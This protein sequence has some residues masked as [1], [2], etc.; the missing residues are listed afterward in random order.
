M[1]F[2]E[3]IGVPDIVTE[4]RGI[5]TLGRNARIHPSFQI[6]RGPTLDGRGIHVGDDAVFFG[7]TMLVLGDP[8]GCPQAN[9]RIGSGVIMNMSA[10]IS[11]EGGLV[12]EDYALIGSNS[13]ILTGGHAIHDGDPIIVKNPL[14]FGSIHIGKSAWVGAGATLIDGVTIGEGAV[15][16]AGS[17][18][19]KDVAPYSVYVGNP[20]RFRHYRR[21]HEPKSF[22]EKRWW[23]FW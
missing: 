22:D 4:F 17:V 5:D 3:H 13:N 14:T 1:S 6:R 19:T 15:V 8:A 21:G 11:G 7:Y 20:A 18:V 9:I 16:G 12:I 10:Y 23:K 2:N